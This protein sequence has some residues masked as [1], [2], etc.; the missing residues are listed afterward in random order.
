MTERETAAAQAG[1]KDLA[2]LKLHP[3]DVP[4]ATVMADLRARFG[5][6][7]SAF[8]RPDVRGMNRADYTAARAGYLNDAA[9]GQRQAADA[10]EQARIAARYAR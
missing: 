3:D 8:A 2:L 4:L 1:L 5:N 9:Q 6:Q 10:A 7:P